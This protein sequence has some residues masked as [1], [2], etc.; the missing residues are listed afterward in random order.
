M[1]NETWHTPG[2]RWHWCRWPAFFDSLSCLSVDPAVFK[3]PLLIRF[4]IGRLRVLSLCQS[5]VLHE[6]EQLQAS[7][8]NK[9]IYL[10]D[11]ARFAD[12]TRHS[13]YYR[14][15]T[16][17]FRPTTK[18]L[19][20]HRI[21]QSSP[22]ADRIVLLILFDSFVFVGWKPQCAKNIRNANRTRRVNWANKTV[23]RS[24]ASRWL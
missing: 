6:F 9:V 8:K 21:C 15:Y 12:T 23:G 16:S 22:I 1:K 24:R 19:P 13:C 5:H 11:A 10:R 2:M 20:G 18:G 14:E 3:H 17:L 4:Q 7:H